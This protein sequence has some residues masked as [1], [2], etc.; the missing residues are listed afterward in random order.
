MAKRQEEALKDTFG[1]HISQLC[2]LVALTAEGK[3]S[4]ALDSTIVTI[5]AEN[6]GL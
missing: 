5:F 1:P 4:A 2:H 3:V 6:P